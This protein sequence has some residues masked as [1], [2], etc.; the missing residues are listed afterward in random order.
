MCSTDIT[1]PYSYVA[2]AIFVVV[3]LW[4]VFISRKTE[5]YFLVYSTVI[6]IEILSV[7]IDSSSHIVNYNHNNIVYLIKY[8]FQINIFYLNLL[9]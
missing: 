2:L 7:I 5:K 1:S 4:T 8:H 6:N 3:P 9:S